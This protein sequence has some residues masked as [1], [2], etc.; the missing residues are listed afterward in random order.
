MSLSESCAWVSSSS[1]C[2]LWHASSSSTP[3]LGD[4]NAVLSWALE[5]DGYTCFVGGFHSW[6]NCFCFLFQK[7]KKVVTN[8]SSL[9]FSPSLSLFLSLFFPFFPRVGILCCHRLA[10]C[11]FLSLLFHSNALFPLTS[12]GYLVLC[13]ST[14]REELLFLLLT[15]AHNSSPLL[16]LVPAQPPIPCEV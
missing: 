12:K 9:L 10:F 14:F 1:R 13:F 8:R 6:R 16:F 11:P 3:T 2:F 4:G 15:S 7:L 5:G